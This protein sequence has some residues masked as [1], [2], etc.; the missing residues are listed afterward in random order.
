MANVFSTPIL[1][2]S[3]LD[4]NQL[5]RNPEDM[6]LARHRHW[7]ALALISPL[8]V[9]VC[10]MTESLEMRPLMPCELY[11]PSWCSMSNAASQ[12]GKCRGAVSVL[13]GKTLVRFIHF[14]NYAGLSFSCNSS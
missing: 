14:E 11:G 10:D 3:I 2:Y 13:L 4:S 6:V 5:P 7:Q 12:P 8:Y 1:P 9:F